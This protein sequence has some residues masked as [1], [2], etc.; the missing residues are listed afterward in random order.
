MC[1]FACSKHKNSMRKTRWA[2]ARIAWGLL[3]LLFLI[4]SGCRQHHT[5]PTRSAYY[6]STTWETDSALTSFLQSNG[7]GKLYLRFFDVVVDDNGKVMPNATLRFADSIPDNMEVVP[8][9][10]IVNDCMKKDVGDLSHLLMKRILQMCET[11]DVPNVKEI[12]IDCDWSP[13]TRNTY[14]GMLSQLR[15]SLHTK[16]LRLSATIRLHQLGEGPPPVDHG[17]LMM[18]NTGDVSNKD[19]NP[20]LDLDDCAP[21]LPNLSKY[22]LPLSAAYPVFSWDLLFRNDRFVGI[23]HGDDLPII[24]G[25]TIIT[26]EVTLATIQKAKEAIQR[27]KPSANDEVILFDI[28]KDNIQRIKQYHYEKIYNH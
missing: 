11:H 2:H 9:V 14:F 23:M 25:D 7:V 6:W 28:S 21:Y 18:Y 24:E 19:K 5:S 3:P 8:T 20:I 13:S 16:G 10:F 27:I 1:K 4:M 12:Q 17:V 26:R 22:D 15:D